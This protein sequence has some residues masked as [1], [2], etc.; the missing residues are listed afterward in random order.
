MLLRSSLFREQRA[1]PAILKLSAL[2]TER[3]EELLDDS[4][5]QYARYLLSTFNG[6]INAL[7][8]LIEND[9]IHQIFRC[10]GFECLIGLSLMGTIPRDY[11]ISYFK[12]LYQSPLCK[13]DQFRTFLILYSGNIYPGDLLKEIKQALTQYKNNCSVEPEFVKELMDLGQSRCIKARLLSTTEFL[14]ITNVAESMYYLEF[15]ESKAFHINDPKVAALFNTFNAVEN[16]FPYK[17]LE[18]ALSMKE[19][20]TPYL[21]EILK[22]AADN[23]ATLDL[24]SRNLMF[25]L[26]LL[27]KFRE[28]RAFEYIV[29]IASLPGE[30]PDELLPVEVFDSLPGFLL[31]TYDGNLEALKGLIEDEFIHDDSRDYALETIVGLVSLG[32]LRRDEAISYCRTLFNSSLCN[33]PWFTANLVWYSC[34]LYPDE[35]L[36]EIQRVYKEEKVDVMLTP[37]EEVEFMLDLDKQEYL[38][39]DLRNMG[40][41]VLIQNV[42]QIMSSFAIFES[43]DDDSCISGCCDEDEDEDEVR[44]VA[45]A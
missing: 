18:K 25:A 21:L 8:S 38:E 11:L 27:S 10:A 16:E 15:F 26:Y 36:P 42:A 33:D 22:D 41:D 12:K 1:F 30:W 4:I 24:S 31:S 28:K 37:F 39:D 43:S 6:D 34:E 14:P 29:K 19:R 32:H 5:G 7:T 2:P 45:Q 23:Y 44:D 9:T 13:N 20:I 35:L 40:R 17:A 3:A